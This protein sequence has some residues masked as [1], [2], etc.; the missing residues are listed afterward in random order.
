M[1]RDF[2]MVFYKV[3]RA[4]NLMIAQRNIPAIKTAPKIKESW[5]LSLKRDGLSPRGLVYFCL[6]VSLSPCLCPPPP[7][8]SL[9]LAP[10]VNDPHPSSLCTFENRVCSKTEL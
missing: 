2:Y 10:S 5:A 9:F 7:V 3:Q 1:T 6:F 8:P 4:V